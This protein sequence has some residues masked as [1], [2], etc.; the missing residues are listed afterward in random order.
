[1]IASP[2]PHRMDRQCYG[3]QYL[4]A[5]AAL[6]VLTHHAF[7][8]DTF[9]LNMLGTGVDLF[10]V[11]SG[12]L[13]VAITDETTRPG[14]FLLARLRRIVPLYWLLTTAI[15]ILMWG[16]VSWR[17]PIPFWYLSVYTT[18]VPGR[19]IAASYAFIPVWNAGAN[20]PWP[21]LPAGW[22]LNL[23]MMFYVLFALS[24]FLPRRWQIPGLSGVLLTLVAVGAL[25][26]PDTP[27]LL[28]W[29]DPVI[30]D[31]VVGAWIGYMWQNGKGLWRGFSI[32]I[33]FILAL[34][35]AM[36]LLVPIEPKHYR[37]VL[38]IPY[39]A[40]L[41]WALKAEEQPGGI[42]RLSLPLFLGNASYSIYLVQFVPIVI[43]QMH[44]VPRGLLYA[45]TLIVATLT[46]ATPLYLWVERPILRLLGKR[47]PASTRQS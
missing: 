34:C 32:I 4:R 1:M 10:F 25:H 47:Q 24:L 8:F 30:I 3:L 9:P 17:S 43:L 14:S 40:L 44:D 26:T 7:K 29:T 31:F 38:S 13:M 16:A 45:S 36:F 37:F 18:E 27:A 19:L 15:V 5:L 42:P 12:F 41:I 21:V 2:P 35:M 28:A 20:R 33:V 23:E 46:M 11:L 22:T 6:M 39:T